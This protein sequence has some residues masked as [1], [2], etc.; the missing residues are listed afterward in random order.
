MGDIT[1]VLLRTIFFYFFILIMFRIMGKR[2][3]GQLGVVDLAVSVL[4][5]ELVAISIENVEDSIWLTILPIIALVI[6]EI[7]LAMINLKCKKFR[8]FFEGKPSVI[9][10]RGKIN[11]KEMVKQR[12]TIDDLLLELRQK[13]IKNLERVEYALLEPNGKLS[14]FKTGAHLISVE[15]PSYNLKEMITYEFKLK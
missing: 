7:T 8:N 5:A 9:I 1:N 6:L 14:I 15:C 13:G 10:N 4:I 11:Y 3:I 2:E 12:Y